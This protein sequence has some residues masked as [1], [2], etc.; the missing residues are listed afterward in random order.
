M[1]APGGVAAVA[2][3]DGESVF[4]A[5]IWSLREFDGKTGDLRSVHRHVSEIRGGLAPPFT[6]TA[7]GDR[8]IL[9]SYIVEDAVQ[10][11]D[12]GTRE[13]LMDIRD[14]KSPLSA[15][16]FRDDLVVA[17]HGTNSVIRISKDN[18]EERVVLAEGLGVPTG[19]AAT[20]N[21]LWVCD[22]ATGLVLQLV[23]G[24][25]LLDEPRV[26]ARGLSYPEGLA[27]DLDGTLLIREGQ[28]GCLKRVD[29]ASS[30]VSP[31]ATGLTPCLQGEHPTWIFNGVAVGPTGTTYITCDATNSLY[32]IEPTH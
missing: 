20:E 7:D 32:R 27:V 29:P 13:V 17:E 19:L 16:R 18:P 8:L 26:V 21:D 4:V 9:T 3:P 25:E 23:A 1:I 5:D 10:V 28:T 2:R 6:V 15:I 14:L 22:Q 12:P 11:Y 24:G 30:E 31:V